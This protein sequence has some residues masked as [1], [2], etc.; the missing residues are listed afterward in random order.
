MLSSQQLADAYKVN[1]ESLI[2]KSHIHRPRPRSQTSV[3]N[4]HL[5]A[6]APKSF[7]TTLDRNGKDARE[8]RNERRKQIIF[9]SFKGFAKATVSVSDLGYAGFPLEFAFGMI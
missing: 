9:H 1:F 4:L 5:K 3:A 2:P 7:Q 6:N 8:D